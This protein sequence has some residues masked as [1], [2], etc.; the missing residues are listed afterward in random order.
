[1]FSIAGLTTVSIEEIQAFHNTE[2]FANN[3]GKILLNCRSMAILSFVN[4]PQNTSATNN[5]P[6]Y[7]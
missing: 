6:S 2:P 3:N 7:H 1:M 4:S 5:N